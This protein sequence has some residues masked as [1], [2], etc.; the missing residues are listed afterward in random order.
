ML[1]IA[2]SS[3]YGW[4]IASE[5]LPKRI[6]GVISQATNSA[7]IVMLLFVVVYLIAGMF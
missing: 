4:I 6:A 3:L 5:Q 7:T 1:M 2:G